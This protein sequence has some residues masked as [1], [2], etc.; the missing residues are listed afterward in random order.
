MLDELIF[1][2]IHV[3]THVYVYSIV[4]NLYLPLIYTVVKYNSAHFSLIHIP[5]DSE[6]PEMLSS[7]NMTFVLI[8]S[9]M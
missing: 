5:T 9:Q 6:R 2:D 4:C 3:Y 7:T 8:W 1:N